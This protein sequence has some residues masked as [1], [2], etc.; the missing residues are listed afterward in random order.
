MN[1]APLPQ[2]VDPK[3]IKTWYPDDEEI[4]K[5]FATWTDDWNKAY[6]YRQ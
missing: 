3:S 4:A 6:H 5:V 2:G 1:D